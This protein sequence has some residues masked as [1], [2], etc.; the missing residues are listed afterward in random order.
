MQY[1]VHE[2]NIPRLCSSK[3]VRT[4]VF[5]FDENYAKYFSVIL[6]SLLDHADPDVLYDLVVLY[7]KLSKRTRT[8]LGQ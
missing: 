4:I 6:L 3:P 2:M 7:D 1:Q 5:S 8:R